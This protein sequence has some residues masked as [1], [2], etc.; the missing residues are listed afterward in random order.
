MRKLVLNPWAPQKP[1]MVTWMPR[2]LKGAALIILILSFFC[3]MSR[4][5]YIVHGVLY[6]YGLNFS[7]DWAVDYWLTYNLT[8]L[9]FSIIVSFSYWFGSNKSAK[10]LKFAIALSLTINALAVGGLQ[11]ILFFVLWAGGLPP[12]NVIWWWAPWKYMLGT[13]TSLTQIGFTVLMTV[14]TMF[15][16]MVATKEKGLSVQAQKLDAEESNKAAH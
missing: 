4:I 3:L 16:W 6:D 10:N 8:F 15:V 5:D 1:S 13:W 7:Y 2:A 14:S 12:N 11:D 9:A